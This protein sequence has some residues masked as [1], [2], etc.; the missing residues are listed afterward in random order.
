[1]LLKP[2]CTRVIIGWSL[3]NCLSSSSVNFYILIFSL[4]PQ[5]QLEPNLVGMFIVWS[6]TRFFCCC[7]EVHKRNN[8]PKG[9]KRVCPYIYTFLKKSPFKE[10]K[11]HNFAYLKGIQNF[12]FHPILM[13]FFFLRWILCKNEYNNFSLKS[14]LH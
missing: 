7:S 10:P 1:M 11:F 13:W 2:T 8:R 4:K 5:C 3:A 6:P 9:V 12:I 14:K